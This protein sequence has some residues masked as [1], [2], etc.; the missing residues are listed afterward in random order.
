[1]VSPKEFLDYY[2]SW[3][4]PAR[5]AYAAGAAARLPA[6]AARGGRV[7]ACGMG[8]SGVAGDYLAALATA[9]G[10]SVIVS[11]KGPR[12][13]A[14][15][16][17]GSLVLAVSF[18]GNTRE[19]LE[20]A[21]RARQQGA[22]VV[23]VT[24]G[25]RLA[26]AARRWGQPVLVVEEAPA[27][28][29]GW[30]QLF[31]TMLGLLSANGLLN[32]PQWDIEAS[33]SL[34]ADPG[35]VEKRGEALAKWLVGADGLVVVVAPEPLYPAAIR[36]RSELAENT[37]MVAAA[38]M[39]PEAGHNELEAWAS[40]GRPLDFLVL[41]PG[42]EP[43]SRL[44]SEA[45]GLAKPSS[46]RVAHAEGGTLLQRLVWFTWLMGVASVKAAIARGVDPYRLTAVKAFRRVVEEATEW[47]SGLDSA[48]PL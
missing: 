15:A 11:S 29:A 45:A 22:Y 24:S 28:R 42:I 18:S 30:P 8:G 34:L 26:A 44:L 6:S 17:E 10:G 39:L 9:Y 33:L 13:P 4:G 20:C 2:L 5:R 19:T 25:G 31:Y 48:P 12:P 37:K 32:V 40:S 43:W 41:D 14:W 46:I 36:A 27:P 35:L 38:T 7:L 16:G 3:S 21:A 1:M 47:G 23:A